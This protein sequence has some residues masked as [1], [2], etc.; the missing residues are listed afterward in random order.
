VPGEEEEVAVAQRPRRGEERDQ[1]PRPTRRSRRDDDEDD[2]RP[3]RPRKKR[4][5]SKAGLVIVLSIVGVL[6]I[7][8]VFV[9]LI[10]YNQG[11]FRSDSGG[12]SSASS[13]KSKPPDR[14]KAGGP[15]KGGGPAIPPTATGQVK[16][17]PRNITDQ[18]APM[19]AFPK[20]AEALSRIEQLLGAPGKRLNAAELAEASQD[21]SVQAVRSQAPNAYCYRWSSPTHSLYVFFDG[22]QW[23]GSA[24]VQKRIR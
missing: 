6:V 21:G 12:D 14:D 11:W 5:S 19:G 22:G 2:D 4:K 7:A 3:R 15:D 17:I 13:D 1:T 24:F 10:G 16:V 9:V 20:E 18:I 8:G 23:R